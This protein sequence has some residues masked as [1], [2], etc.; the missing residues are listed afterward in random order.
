M[1]RKAAMHFAMTVLDNAP[2]GRDKE[3]ALQKIE[4][5]L[6]WANASIARHSRYQDGED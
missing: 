2:D 4:E 3:I 1:F 5:G 6:F